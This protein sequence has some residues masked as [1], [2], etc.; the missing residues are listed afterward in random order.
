VKYLRLTITDT[1]G[2][3]DDYLGDFVFDPANSK[4]FSTW[5]RVPDD[6]LQDGVL[7]PE[8]RERLFE[9]LYGTEWRL[10]NGDGSKYVVLKVEEHGLS[11]IEVAQRAWV[12]TDESCYAVVDGSRIETISRDAM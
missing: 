1:M 3:W 8:R 2:F 10:G 7:V 6:W 11:D 4:T 12:S 9:Y 5:Y